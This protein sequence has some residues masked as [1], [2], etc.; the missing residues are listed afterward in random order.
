MS[1][2]GSRDI[3]PAL[4]GTLQAWFGE[5]VP[6]VQ[7]VLGGDP[8]CFLEFVKGQCLYFLH[9]LTKLYHVEYHTPIVVPRV[10]GGSSRGRGEE[11]E[12]EEG[13]SEGGTQGRPRA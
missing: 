8:F 13:R 3:G 7:E 12:M 9:R 2:T 5:S 4:C 1:V 10:F 11:G 6:K